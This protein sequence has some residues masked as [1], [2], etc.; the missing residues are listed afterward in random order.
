MLPNYFIQ[1]S[2]FFFNFDSSN[3]ISTVQTGRHFILFPLVSHIQSQKWFI[4]L[5]TY[6]NRFHSNKQITTLRYQ[7][8]GSSSKSINPKWM[9]RGVKSG[10]L[11]N[12]FTLLKCM[13]LFW[14]TENKMLRL[15][16]MLCVVQ[17]NTIIH[18]ET[19]SGYIEESSVKTIC[20]HHNRPFILLTGCTSWLYLQ[21]WSFI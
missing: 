10:S 12:P 3:P 9:I 15:L 5:F 11:F 7:C 17:S 8:S 19:C 18:L 6:S 2:H 4:F 16:T 21:L 14:S 13:W 20:W 1:F